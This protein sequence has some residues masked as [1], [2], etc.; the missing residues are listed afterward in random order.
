MRVTRCATFTA[1]LLAIPLCSVGAGQDARPAVVV[2]ATGGT[3]AGAGASDVAAGYTSARVAVDALIASVPDAAKLARL[4]GEQVASIGSQ[5][6]TDAVWLA[7]ARR[8]NEVAADP[9]VGGIVI[10]H[11]TDTL[12][13]TAY[14]LN[15][16]VKTRKPVVMTGAMRPAT[17]LSADGPLNFYN[18][19]A[20]AASPDALGNGVLVVINEGIHDA[21]SLTKTS[22]TAVEAFRSP[23]RGLVG[24]VTWGTVEFFRAPHQRHT[25]DTEFSIEGVEILPRVEI[26]MAYAD[27]PGDLIDAAANAG[28]KGIVVAGVGNGNMSAAALEALTR[29]ARKGIVCVRST[30]V[31]SGEVGRNVEVDDDGRGLIASDELNAQKARVLLKLALIT[32][33]PVAEIQRMFNE[34]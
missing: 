34:Y 2:L 6:M 29:A 20:V 5:D 26:V 32:P 30:R 11:G 10:T 9:A 23:V 18:A 33:R 3:I 7:L 21:A 4:R 15:L 14:F 17:A 19:V 28:A 1:F 25:V 22:T 24:L 12:E 8:V 27:M 13:E 31:A 16:V